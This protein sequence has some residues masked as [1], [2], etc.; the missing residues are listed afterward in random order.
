MRSSFVFCLSFVLFTGP[1]TV[2][3]VEP[4]HVAFGAKRQNEATAI[5]QLESRFQ[6]LKAARVEAL[7][8]LQSKEA[9]QIVEEILA[10]LLK[11][12]NPSPSLQQALIDLYLRHV[13]DRP[14]DRIFA[15]IEAP[16]FQLLDPAEVA[17]NPFIMGRL[18]RFVES[19]ETFGY[20]DL[21]T[22]NP[23]LIPILSSKFTCPD[24]VLLAKVDHDQ[25]NLKQQM[26]ETRVEALKGSR[27]RIYHL[28]TA[29]ASTLTGLEA[30]EIEQV[31]LVF[32]DLFEMSP[33]HLEPYFNDLRSLVLQPDHEDKVRTL[34]MHIIWKASVAYPELRE[35]YFEAALQVKDEMTLVIGGMKRLI[36]NGPLTDRERELLLQFLERS[37]LPSKMPVTVSYLQ[38]IRR[39]S[40]RSVSG[41]S[42]SGLTCSALFKTF[43]QSK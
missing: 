14:E 1:L 20:R 8:N 16:I 33:R 29:P 32:S 4:I 40:F 21:L 11:L 22:K 10:E 25:G 31:L 41:K 19:P 38:Q 36:Q 43:D 13:T 9:L 18:R 28:F 42:V 5:Q 24:R 23:K 27:D 30:R 34:A 17:K 3:A 15:A 39:A 35:V 7:R 12:Q 2:H 26:L 37:D 6:R